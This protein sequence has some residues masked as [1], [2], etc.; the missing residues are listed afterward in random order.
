MLR[1]ST[2]T[3]PHE[4]VIVLGLAHG[5]VHLRLGWLDL[6]AEPIMYR[7]ERLL[8]VMD[9]WYADCLQALNPSI[10]S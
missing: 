9:H 4:H 2:S 1:R 8:L 5:Y 10:T 6:S 3:C 7:F